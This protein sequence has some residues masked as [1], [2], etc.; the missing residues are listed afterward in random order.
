V[1]LNP[2]TSFEIVPLPVRLTVQRPD[3]GVVV[4]N[5]VGA[6][7]RTIALSGRDVRE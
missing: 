4:W 6:T 5:G 1:S 7:T 3:V 2:K